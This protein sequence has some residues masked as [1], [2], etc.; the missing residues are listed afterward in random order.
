MAV[1][2]AHSSPNLRMFDRRVFCKLSGLQ[3]GNDAFKG[4]LSRFISK[5]EN[6]QH[7]VPTKEIS[8]AG[9]L[10]LPLLII[11]IGARMQ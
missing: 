8:S 9:E 2:K 3:P 10:S 11:Q 6:N 1:K 5:E 7:G 4:K